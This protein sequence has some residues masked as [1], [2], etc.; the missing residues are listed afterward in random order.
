MNC[1]DTFWLSFDF[2]RNTIWFGE[3]KIRKRATE[4]VE[5]EKC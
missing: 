4:D 5:K 1:D 3:R 2:D